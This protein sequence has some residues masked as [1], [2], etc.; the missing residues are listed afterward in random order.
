MWRSSSAFSSKSWRK[1]STGSGFL[2]R[3][4]TPGL[5]VKGMPEVGVGLPTEEGLAALLD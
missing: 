2:S 4:D 3:P 5:D 1:Q